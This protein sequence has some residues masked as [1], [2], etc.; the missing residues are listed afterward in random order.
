[1]ILLIVVV[2]EMPT[3]GPFLEMK[4]FPKFSTKI[5]ES[6]DAPRE[7]NLHWVNPHH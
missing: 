2:N 6:F 4:D 7:I 5:S 3:F 1:M